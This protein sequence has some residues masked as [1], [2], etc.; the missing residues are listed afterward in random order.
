MKKELQ[1]AEELKERVVAYFT[2][3]AK[4]LG[5]P[6]SVGEI[7]GL[8]YMTEE[9]LCLDDIMTRLDMSKGSVSQGLKT[10]REFGA[11][12]EVSVEKTRKVFYKAQT[13]LKKLV[14][15][16]IKTQI[17]PHLSEGEQELKTLSDLAGESQ[18]P[19]LKERIYKL[20]QWSQR[21]RFT[22]PLIQKLLGE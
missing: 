6:P 5:I 1:Q 14:G 9:P 2:S 16:Y 3:T 17:R 11:L 22:L 18:S 10:L 19:F 15:G 20:G 13:E 21:S 8:L 12:E 4:L 7:Y